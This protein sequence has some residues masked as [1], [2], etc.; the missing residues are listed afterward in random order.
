MKV[1]VEVDATPQELRSFLGLP[2]VE[3]LQQE[4]MDQVRQNMLKA[5][6]QYDPATLMKTYLPPNIPALEAMQKSFWDTFARGIKKEPG[7]K[8]G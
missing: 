4:V 2:D 5:I 7:G 1:K 8:Q 6:E 3:P